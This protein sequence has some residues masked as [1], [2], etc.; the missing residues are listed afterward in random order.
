MWQ[1]NFLLWGNYIFSFLNKKW[2]WSLSQS[3][4]QWAWILTST[5][6]NILTFE[7]AERWL[8]RDQGSMREPVLT[9]CIMRP[10]VCYLCAIC[11]RKER[12]VIHLSS[13]T[14]TCQLYNKE[15]PSITAPKRYGI[16]SSTTEL[17]YHSRWIKSVGLCST[18]LY[19]AHTSC[20]TLCAG[21]LFAWCIRALS[22]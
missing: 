17:F 1:R 21:S 2:L 11:S 8:S 16:M 15:K 14:N 3:F 9:L 12:C 7:R 22:G 5:N 6:R 10:A 4:L 20:Q 18:A 19:H 13:S